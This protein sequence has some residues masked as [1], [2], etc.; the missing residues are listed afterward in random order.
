MAEVRSPADR[1][2]GALVRLSRLSRA[3]VARGGVAAGENQ[4]GGIS[5]AP[6]RVAVRVEA[7]AG[8]TPQATSHT[9]AEAP[10]EEVLERLERIEERLTDLQRPQRAIPASRDLFGEWVRLRTWEELGWGDF[11]KLRRLG[12]I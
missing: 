5:P 6:A 12:R 10:F 9:N 7:K 4:A 11:L 1:F 3:S 2:Q 8:I